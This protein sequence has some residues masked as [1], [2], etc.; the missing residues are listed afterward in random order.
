MRLIALLSPIMRLRSKRQV[1]SWLEGCPGIGPVRRKA[2]LQTFGSLQKI[3]RAAVGELA[4]VPGMTQQAA[5]NLYDY[6]RTAPGL[7][8]KKP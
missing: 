8:G 6:I 7:R 3:K 1:S 2:L 4:A 5:E